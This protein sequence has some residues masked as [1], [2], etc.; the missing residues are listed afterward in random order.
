MDFE[1]LGRMYRLMAN[2]M[3]WDGTEYLHSPYCRYIKST[4]MGKFGRVLGRLDDFGS[5]LGW[6]YVLKETPRINES[7][8]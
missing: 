1:R 4:G 6:Y 5:G 3:D 7:V 2:G 8:R